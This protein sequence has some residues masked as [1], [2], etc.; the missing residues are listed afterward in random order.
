MRSSRRVLATAGE[1]D[2]PGSLITHLRK[3][4]SQTGWSTKRW[5]KSSA[6]AL[7][8]EEEAAAAEEEEEVSWVKRPVHRAMITPVVSSGRWVRR[9]LPYLWVGE[10]VGGWGRG[11]RG[12]LNEL[13]CKL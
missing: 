3:V 1:T 13:T 8:G 11:E 5:R 7:G 6:A 2:R 9:R 12:G 10:W 4:R